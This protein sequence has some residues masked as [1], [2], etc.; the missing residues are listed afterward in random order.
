V[1]AFQNKRY[2]SDELAV[3]VDRAYNI[4]LLCSPNCQ[5]RDREK[6]AILYER[7]LYLL[8]KCWLVFVCC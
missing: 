1:I 7:M 6:R 3:T 5:M 8:S 2:P 4:K